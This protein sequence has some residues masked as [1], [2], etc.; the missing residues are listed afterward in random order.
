MKELIGRLE[1]SRAIWLESLD[2][3][4]E[5]EARWREGEDRWSVLDCAEHV[6]N[7]EHRIL[8]ALQNAPPVDAKPEDAQHESWIY[9]VTRSRETAVAAP[10][11]VLPAG[12]YATLAEAADAFTGTRNR[13]LEFLKAYAGDLRAIGATH[14]LLGPCNGYEYALI[15]AAHPIRHASQIREI[16]EARR[17]R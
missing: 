11:L 8:R 15:M 2:G 16:R 17:A 3:V 10:G 4:E 7:V 1:E 14:P 12:R 9:E 6:A 5:E 13:A